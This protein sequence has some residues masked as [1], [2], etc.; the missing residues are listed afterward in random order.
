MS[1]YKKAFG[2]D[3]LLVYSHR[4]DEEALGFVRR[5]IEHL[6]ISEQAAILDLCC[7]AGR[8]AVQCATAGYRVVGVD[9]SAPLLA[10]ASELTRGSSLPIQWVQAD[11][12]DIPVKSEFDL[13]LNLFTSF[14]YFEEN[15]ENYRVI[16]G[17]HEAL[18]P[19]G[20]L[21]L[22]FFNPRLVTSSL[23]PF[24]KSTINGMTV[25]QIREVDWQAQRIIKHVEITR[26]GVTKKYR[27]SVRLYDKADLVWMMLDAGFTVEN[28]FGGYT[29]EPWVESSA[30]TIVVARKKI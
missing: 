3:Y 5:L 2:E 10:R 9:L 15:E 26:D 14:G 30:R 6:D 24:D 7:G 11:M 1:W 18:K 17:I 4:D 16:T 23:V 25:T 28:T 8:H 20:R 29:L 13:V 27:E 19:G 12:R 22:D 21:V